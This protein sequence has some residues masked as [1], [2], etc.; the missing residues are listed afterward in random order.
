[1]FLGFFIRAVINASILFACLHI[2]SRRGSKPDFQD[3]FYVALGITLVS[4][5]LL[6]LLVPKIGYFALVPVFIANVFIL[7]QFLGMSIP[8]A[9]V[10]IILYETVNYILPI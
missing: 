5:L 3:V 10:V 9:V 1:M 8:T 2:V 4:M 6:V 7:I